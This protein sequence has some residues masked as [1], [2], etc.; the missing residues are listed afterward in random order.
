MEFRNRTTSQ[1][2]TRIE[3]PD[4]IALRNP[5]MK[6]IKAIT[7]C[8]F[9]KQQKNGK[10]TYQQANGLKVSD[11]DYYVAKASDINA[12][13]PALVRTYEYMDDEVYHACCT[14]TAYIGV[15]E[16]KN[17]T[18]FF[19]TMTRPVTGIFTGI[20]LHFCES[21]EPVDRKAVELHGVKQ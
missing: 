7:L 14:C 9:V 4:R 10:A 12:L 20:E 19:S 11:I 13:R 8:V 2:K 1:T 15:E 5:F 21:C 6:G 16:T 18:P 3:W 17:M